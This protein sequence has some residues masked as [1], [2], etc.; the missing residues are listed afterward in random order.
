MVKEVGEG[1]GAVAELSESGALCLSHTICK[2]ELIL[3]PEPWSRYEDLRLVQSQCWSEQLL[4]VRLCV[5][6][7][8]GLQK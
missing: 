5:G 6:T 4:A 8:A 1:R 7:Q 2:M 3:A